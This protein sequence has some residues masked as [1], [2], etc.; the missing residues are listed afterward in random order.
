MLPYLDEQF[1]NPSSTHVYGKAAHTAVESARAE[2]GALLGAEA[3]E[4]IF[5]GGGSGASNHA[6]KGAALTRPSGLRS[7]LFRRE[8]H[9]ITSAIEHPATREPCEFLRRFG[10]SLTVVPVDGTGRVNPEDVR[11]AI[12]RKTVLITIMHSNN[13]V[14]TLQ[15][16][17]EIAAIARQH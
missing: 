14:G 12:T 15:P 13:E 1:G 17:R 10:C 2:L 11:K 3:D 4:I 8:A 5:T 6:I 9:V 7:A 16:I